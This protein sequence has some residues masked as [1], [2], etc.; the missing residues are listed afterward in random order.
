MGRRAR[1]APLRRPARGRRAVKC[2]CDWSVPASGR[3]YIY[4]GLDWA[5]VPLGQP[6]IN[7]SLR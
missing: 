4:G 6:E 1:A 7:G 3:V 5:A 2:E